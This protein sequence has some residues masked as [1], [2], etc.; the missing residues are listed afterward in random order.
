V[1]TNQIL[2]EIDT[3][4]CN[5]CGECLQ[6]CDAGALGMVSNMAFLARPDLCQYDGNCE[7]ACPTGAIS[8]PYVVV[9]N[10]KRAGSR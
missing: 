3:T 2:P 6:A 1:K 4:A 7:P 9:L 8:L 5:G 10:V